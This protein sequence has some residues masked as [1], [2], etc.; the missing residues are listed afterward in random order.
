MAIA[1]GIPLAKDLGSLP[2]NICTP[3]YLAEQA[4]ELGS[5]HCFQVNI[6][7]QKD[8]E[9]LGMSAFLAVAGGSRQPP[10]L[11]VM[12]YHGGTPDALPVV[13]VGRESRLTRAASTSSPPQ[14]WRR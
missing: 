1:E 10:K 3:T 5:H 14:G 6:L 9:K 8:I 4:R 13:L 11:I 2:G 7:D 12:E